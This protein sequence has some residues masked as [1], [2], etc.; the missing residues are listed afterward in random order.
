MKRARC[1]HHK[2]FAGLID[3]DRTFWRTAP[4]NARWRLNCRP[5]SEPPSAVTAVG[6]TK[7]GEAQEWPVGGVITME[8]YEVELCHRGRWEQ[9]EARFVAARDADEAAHKVTG[10]QLRSE[11][12]AGRFGYASAG[13]AMEA[14]RPRCFM[15]SNGPSRPLHRF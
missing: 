15:P 8:I 3:A 14:H 13:L 6:R 4:T 9:Q 10:R 5:T 11:G 12:D 2:K 7:G 1:D